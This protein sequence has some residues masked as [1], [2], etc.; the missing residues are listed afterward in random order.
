MRSAV[1]FVFGHVVGALLIGAVGGALI[2]SAS[3]ASFSVIMTVAA[4]ASATVCKWLPGY[5]APW[6]QLWLAGAGTNPL[7]LVA[8]SFSLDAADCVAGAR[9]GPACLFSDIGPLVVGVCLLPPLF[10]LGLRWLWAGPARP[11]PPGSGD[12]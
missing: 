9:K 3:I 6:W 1:P 10:G 11:R 12:L 4:A 7:L 2:N 5:D 8:L